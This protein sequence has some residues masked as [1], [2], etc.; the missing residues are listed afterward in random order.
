MGG[1]NEL[2][3]KAIDQ[4]SLDLPMTPEDQEKLVRF[5]VSEAYLDTNDHKYKAFANRGP[6]DPYVLSALL[7][8]N[9]TRNIRSVPQT[10]GT[11]AV[12]MFEPIGGMDMIW[13]PGRARSGRTASR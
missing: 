6:G 13:K 11:A 7:Q 1:V 3:V 4:K 5:L 2:L 10:E 9:F 8:G 12:P